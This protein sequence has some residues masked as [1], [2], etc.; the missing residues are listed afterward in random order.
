MDEEVSYCGFL[1]LPSIRFFGLFIPDFMLPAVKGVTYTLLIRLG[2][3]W[4]KGTGAYEN[5]TFGTAW[6]CYPTEY[7]RNTHTR[8]CVKL[9]S[10][11]PYG[12]FDALSIIIGPKNASKFC[13]AKNFSYRP[14]AL[15]E[16]SRGRSMVYIDVMDVDSI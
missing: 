7:F 6:G 4:G 16:P 11:S 5:G 3:V 15:P 2:I 9:K 10:E 13:G 1:F 8:L 14:P 12:P